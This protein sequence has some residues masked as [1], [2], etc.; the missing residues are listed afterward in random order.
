MHDPW[1]IDMHRGYEFFLLNQAKARNP[2]IYTY[3]LPWAFPQWVSCNPNTLTNC[4]GNPY[5]LPQQTA[6]YITSWVNGVKTEYGIDID[7]IGCE[8]F[9]PTHVS[10]PPSRCFSTPLTPPAHTQPFQRGTREAIQ[11]I[12]WRPFEAPWMPAD[13]LPQN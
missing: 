6:N 5:S 13:F 7:Y 12:I 3:G 8:V 10:P 1:T 2:S 11:K 9:S 4:T